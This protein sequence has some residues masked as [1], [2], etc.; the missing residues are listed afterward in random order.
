MPKLHPKIPPDG[1]GYELLHD[2]YQTLVSSTSKHQSDNQ[3]QTD[4]GYRETRQSSKFGKHN[5]PRFVLY[6]VFFVF[7][8][9]IAIFVIAAWHND[10]AV[11]VVIA[12]AVGDAFIRLIRHFVPQIVNTKV[13]YAFIALQCFNLVTWISLKISRQVALFDKF[14]QSQKWN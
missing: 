7:F 1:F 5:T 11:L 8:L 4:S 2:V 9:L 10:T 14:L 3:T 13:N 6:L 12:Y